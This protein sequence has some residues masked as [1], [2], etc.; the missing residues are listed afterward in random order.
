MNIKLHKW[1][2]FYGVNIKS[3]SYNTVIIKGFYIDS[4]MIIPEMRMIKLQR[5]I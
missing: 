5:I 2:I 1:A 3:Y 4:Q